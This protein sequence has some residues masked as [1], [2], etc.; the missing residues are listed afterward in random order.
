MGFHSMASV[1]GAAGSVADQSKYHL[2]EDGKQ[3]VLR[4]PGSQ[5]RTDV[6]WRSEKLLN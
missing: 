1:V 6:A 5:S 4:L 3:V 2:S